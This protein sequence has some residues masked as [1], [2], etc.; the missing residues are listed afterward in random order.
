MF[1]VHSNPLNV[2][3]DDTLVSNLTKQYTRKSM[4]SKINRHTSIFHNHSLFLSSGLAL[5][6][7]HDLLRPYTRPSTNIFRDRK[8]C[9][10]FF[11]P[12]SLV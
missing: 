3:Y 6:S 9:R 7:D 4:L 10:Q 2:L 11:I 8:D 12:I 1:Y 5:N